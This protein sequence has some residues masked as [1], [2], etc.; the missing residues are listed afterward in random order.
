MTG[1]REC[2]IIVPMVPPSPNQLRRKYRHFMAYKR[3]RDGWQT[4]INALFGAKGFSY[5]RTHADARHRTSVAIHVE[6]TRLFDPD[7][8]V[9]AMKPILDSLCNLGYIVGDSG[10]WIDLKPTQEKSTKQQTVIVL[11]PLYE[12]TGR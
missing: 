11:T 10:E 3:L 5:L 8:L 12:R 9:G 1:M 6:H 2:R 7:N 4:A